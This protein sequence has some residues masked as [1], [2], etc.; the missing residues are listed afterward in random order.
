MS[1]NCGQCNW[2][3]EFL[4]LILNVNCHL[5]L[6]STT[7]DNPN[8]E[9]WHHRNTPSTQIL[10]SKYPSPLKGTRVPSRNGWF[11]GWGREVTRW[12]S[13]VPENKKVLKEKTKWRHGTRTP[14][15][16]WR[17]FYLP[18]QG[19]LQLT[20]LNRNRRVLWTIDRRGKIRLEYQ[21]HS[22]SYFLTR[23]WEEPP[24]TLPHFIF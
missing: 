8:L 11:H 9:E 19:Q 1:L 10:A 20:E 16:S 4:N 7:W 18:N 14:R 6:V 13:C 15:A 2:R 12:A 5:E 22:S 17:G 24:S 23:P 21:G 3:T